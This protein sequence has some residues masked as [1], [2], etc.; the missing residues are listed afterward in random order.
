[1][2][3]PHLERLL[4]LEMTS[5]KA[6]LILPGIVTGPDGNIMVGLV[7]DDRG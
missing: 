2:M 6:G 7:F 5:N 1:M 4:A 3:K